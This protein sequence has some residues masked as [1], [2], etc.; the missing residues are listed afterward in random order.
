MF[1][2]EEDYVLAAF[3]HPNYKQL[4]GATH[5]QIAICHASCRMSLISSSSPVGTP[6]GEEDEQPNK[7][8]KRLMMALMDKSKKRRKVSSSDEVD[9]YNELYI[10]DNDQFQNPLNFWKRKDHQMSF[11]NLSRLALRCFSVPCSSAAV[12]R[13]F[14]AAG[15]LITQRRSSLDPATVNNILFLRSPEKNPSVIQ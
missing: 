4:R 13:Q 3:L 12:E 14:S 9:R 8:G 7:N 10:D 1:T 15:Q 11:P 5:S 2:M 6:S